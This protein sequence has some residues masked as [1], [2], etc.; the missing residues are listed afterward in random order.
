MEAGND[1][2]AIYEEGVASF[3]KSFDELVESIESK[4]Q[5]L[6]PA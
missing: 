3:A 1:A 4:R 5:E 2:R 6:A